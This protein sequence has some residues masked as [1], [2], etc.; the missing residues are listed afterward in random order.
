M[1]KQ[2]SVAKNIW[3]HRSYA[4]VAWKNSALAFIAFSTSDLICICKENG[5]NMKPTIL[6]ELWEKWS[7]K[8]VRPWQNLKHFDVMSCWRATSSFTGGIPKFMKG[9]HLNV[10]YT[11]FAVLFDTIFATFSTSG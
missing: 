8:F 11:I 4:I 3:A 9:T 1:H 5:N 10:K 2:N 6:T 7:V